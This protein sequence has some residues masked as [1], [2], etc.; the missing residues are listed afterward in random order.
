MYVATVILLAHYRPLIL[1]SSDLIPGLRL[2]VAY[3][4][5]DGVVALL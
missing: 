3:R 2:A 4:A 1:L 5:G